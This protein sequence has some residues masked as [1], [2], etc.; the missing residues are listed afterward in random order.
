[1]LEIMK[2]KEKQVSQIFKDTEEKLEKILANEFK[3]FNI[4]KVVSHEDYDILK[5]QKDDKS[6]EF[7]LVSE[8]YNSVK[9]NS[10]SKGLYFRR[11]QKSV[12]SFSKKE[13]SEIQARLQALY[14]K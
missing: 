7:N 13:F 5:L 2:E 1:M 9:E 4:V 11:V 10:H 8:R 6:V 12:Q 14:E 3:E